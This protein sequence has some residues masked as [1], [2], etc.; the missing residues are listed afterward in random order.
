[1]FFDFRTV[2]RRF[3]IFIIMPLMCKM[4]VLYT[5]VYARR[6][7]RLYFLVFFFIFL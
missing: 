6:G 4:Q 3:I 5:I 2:Y 7:V 1:M